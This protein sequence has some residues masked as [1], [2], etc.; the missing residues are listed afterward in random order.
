MLNKY[1]NA[2][3]MLTANIIREIVRKLRERLGV[4]SDGMI[5]KKKGGSAYDSI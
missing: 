3:S 4:F 5:R 2:E 1:L